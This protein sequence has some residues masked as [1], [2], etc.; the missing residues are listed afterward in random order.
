MTREQTTG[1]PATSRTRSWTRRHREL[2][3]ELLLVVGLY[4]GYSATRLAATGAWDV[5][6]D[7]ARTILDLERTLNLDIEHAVNTWVSTQP[8]L[9]IATSYWYQ[10]MHYLVTPTLLVLL[11]FRRPLLYRPARTALL[12]ATFVALAGYVFLPTAPP[13]LLGQYVDTV[14]ESAAHGWWPSAAEQAAMGASSVTNQ[15]A[16]MPSMHVGWAMWVSLVLATLTR[17]WWLKALAGCYVLA[18]TFVVVVTANHWIL[19]A[20]AGA[21]IVVACWWFAGRSHGLWAQRGR[22]EAELDGLV[23]TVRA[24]AADAPGT[25]SLAGAAE[26]KPEPDPDEPRR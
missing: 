20:V 23:A 19:D 7:H 8:W 1:E 15:V 18:T 9:E 11:F 25:R 2:L 14:S 10:S 24:P 5:A 22:V 4:A 6:A 26:P 21:A 12:A 17:R 13:R 3:R 16:A